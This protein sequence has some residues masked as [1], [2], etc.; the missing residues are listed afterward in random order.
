ML[1]LVLVPVMATL[2]KSNLN[3]SV[4]V[5]MLFIFP[6]NTLLS[7]NTDIPIDSCKISALSLLESSR[8]NCL[9]P[10]LPV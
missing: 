3:V 1:K 5:E 4:P 2:A 9:V 10:V 6:R 8:V 7:L